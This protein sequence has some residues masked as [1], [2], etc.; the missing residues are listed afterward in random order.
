MQ[1]GF[2]WGL[3]S[4]PVDGYI[5]HVSS[6]A[7]SSDCDSVQVFSSN[8]DTRRMRLEP[9][10]VTLFYLFKDPISKYGHIPSYGFKTSTHVLG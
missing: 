10:H 5:L 7:L 9:T 3:S 2:F 8:K 4:W 1:D 6:Q